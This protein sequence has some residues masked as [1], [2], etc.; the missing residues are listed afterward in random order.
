M[1]VSHNIVNSTTYARLK[2][3]LSYRCRFFYIY[4]KILLFVLFWKLNIVSFFISN[5][6]GASGLLAIPF[7]KYIN[8]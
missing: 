2:P 3:L 5:L 8:K 4:L 6:N 7:V 1:T